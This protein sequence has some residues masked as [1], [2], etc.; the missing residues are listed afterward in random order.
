[1]SLR[2]TAAGSLWV[3]PRPEDPCT[4][5]SL[6]ASARVVDSSGMWL[7]RPRWIDQP[8]ELRESARDR[9]IPAA[10]DGFR[11]AADPSQQRRVLEDLQLA[12]DAI[13]SDR[14]GFPDVPR[15]R[16]NARERPDTE[17]AA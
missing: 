12:M 4:A 6:F 11:H 16:T 9:R 7:T 5:R 15:R 3:G 13:L 2:S 1:L 17:A 10:I 14:A 8:R